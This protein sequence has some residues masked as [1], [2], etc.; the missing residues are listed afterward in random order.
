[1]SDDTHGDLD[2]I[3]DDPGALLGQ[4]AVPLVLV[5]NAELISVL[6]GREL[7]F[8][9][10]DGDPVRIRLYNTDELLAEQKAAA[11]SL[12]HDPGMTRKQAIQL[13][14]PLSEVMRHAR[15]TS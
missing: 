14:M 6:E 5:T 9:T 2:A 4:A 15:R 3:L 7:H 10:M 13:C 11:D 12:G 1:M 8:S